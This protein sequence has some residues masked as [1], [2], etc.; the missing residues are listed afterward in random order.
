VLERPYEAPG[1]HMR[2]LDTSP[3][4]GDG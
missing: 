2:N 4:I 1:L 3:L